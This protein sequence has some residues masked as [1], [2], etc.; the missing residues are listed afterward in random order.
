MASCTLI[1]TFTLQYIHFQRKDSY[2]AYQPFYAAS[3]CSSVLAVFVFL[4]VQDMLTP[5]GSTPTSLG[6]VI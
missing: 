5:L 2:R 4:K 1:C 3:G 6:S